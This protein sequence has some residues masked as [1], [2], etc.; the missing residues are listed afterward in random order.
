[1][2]DNIGNKIKTLSKLLCYVGMA[3]CIIAGIVVATIDEDLILIGVLVAVVGSALSWV[4][5]FL[6]YG[7]GQLVENSD[8]I[9]NRERYTYK[10]STDKAFDFSGRFGTPKAEPKN[11]AKLK[12]LKCDICGVENTDVVECTIVD[13][14]GTRYR[15]MCA[16]CQTQYGATPSI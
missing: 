13:D 3:V 1:M 10:E 4:N 8:I 14:M 5:S 16:N 9:A 7:F 12:M 11:T 2:F 6:L 15:N